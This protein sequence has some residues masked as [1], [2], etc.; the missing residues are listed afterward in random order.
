[1]YIHRFL[2]IS[3]FL[4]LK[5]QAQYFTNR[6]SSDILHNIEKLQNTSRVLYVAAHPDDENTRLITWLAN[7]RKATVAYLSLTRGEG[8]QNLIGPELEDALGII[9][10]Q[11]LLKAREID[12]GLQFFSR[13]RDFGYSKSMEET[14][15]RWN[16]DSILKDV[17][18][19]IRRFKPDIII[20]RFPPDKRAGHGHHSASAQL[21]LKAFDLA[22]DPDY[23]QESKALYGLWQPTRLFW[24]TSQWWIS[25]LDTTQIGT[26]SLLKVP[27]GDYYPYLGAETGE[28]AAFSRSQHKSQGFGIPATRGMIYEYLLLEKGRP[29]YVD[30][31]DDIQAGYARWGCPA[32]DRQARAIALTFNHDRPN[33][34][35]Y[36][37]NEFKKAVQQC[38]P[39]PFLADL[40]N[41]IDELIW[42]CSGV[43]AEVT[44]ERGICVV[45]ELIKL[46]INVLNRIGE[47]VFVESVALSDTNLTIKRLIQPGHTWSLT[48]NHRLR[49]DISQPFWL[50]SPKAYIY[51]SPVEW[52]GPAVDDTESIT[53][54]FNVEG[55]ELQRRIPITYKFNDRIKGEIVEN[56][57]RFPNL[58]ASAEASV[59][60]KIFDNTLN[61]NF[62]LQ[63]HT[64]LDTLHLFLKGS[65]NIKVKQN[66]F[67]FSDLEA[68]KLTRLEIEGSIENDDPGLLSLHVLD[69]K[70]SS[71]V[72]SYQKI[73]YD[74]I[75]RHVIFKPLAVKVIK[76]Q[77]QNVKPLNIGYIPGSGDGLDVILRNAG[78][79]VTEIDPLRTAPDQLQMFDV[80]ICGIRSYN[81]SSALAD[82]HPSLIDYVENGGTYI[83]Q[84][85]TSSNDLKVRNPGPYPFTIGRG[86]ITDE[87]A[88]PLILN[89][90]HK[91]LQRP[92]QI[93]K[94]DLTNWIQEIGLYFADDIDER[95]EMPLAWADPEEDPQTGGL[96]IGEFGKGIFIYTGLSFFRQIP[97]GHPGAFKL[98]IN[99]LHANQ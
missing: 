25:D 43:Y 76:L 12:G 95:Y 94:E 10:T 33:L 37:L 18:T 24:N 20:N 69:D 81:T 23:D 58:T 19:I 98:F 53:V 71:D 22:A 54:I 59:L 63:V 92:Y 80:I 39:E 61:L 46:N 11:E 82:L 31:F 73:E 48:V 51:D 17:V 93:S 77:N 8:G 70:D 44:A 68:N 74:H 4:V 42:Q 15:R 55:A 41:K 96:I 26:G 91:I 45:N 84:Y 3:Y 35:I 21:A 90:H 65:E 88:K 99:L 9:R 28:L 47:M 36:K 7:S 56:I 27:V 64:S 83:V 79:S 29:A 85:Q 30:I 75:G 97:A 50:K 5:C 78:F 49:S 66:I 16:E 60:Y 72:M 38:V 62:S 34:S 1:M 40:Q 14:L 52:I 57:I 87:G 89:A 67:T 6:H 32:L 86:R 13:A 2:V